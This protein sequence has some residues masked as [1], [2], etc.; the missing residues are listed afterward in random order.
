MTIKDQISEVAT[1]NTFA[2]FIS[3]QPEALVLATW[4]LEMRFY[5]P[6]SNVQN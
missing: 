3:H 1:K 2:I 5:W 6:I 4:M